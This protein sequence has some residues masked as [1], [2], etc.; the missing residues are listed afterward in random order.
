MPAP[1]DDFVGPPRSWVVRLGVPLASYGVYF[2]TRYWV[3]PW[4]QRGPFAFAESLAPGPRLLAGHL[5]TWQAPQTA[6]A[7]LTFFLLVRTG[8]LKWPRGVSLAS[9]L[10]WGVV[11]GLAITAVTA[12]IWFLAGPGF[13][14][15]VNFWKMAGNLVSNYYEELAFR[16]LLFGATLYAFRSFWPAAILSGLA[17]GL[18]HTQYPLVFRVFATTV[19]VVWA[20]AYWRTR[21][22]LS[23]WLS[24][25]LSDMLLDTF[26]KG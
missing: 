18:G 5:L 20:L 9:T 12:A 8:V 23:P 7:A 26:L 10:R 22:L 1:L 14:V 6:V 13:Q 16:G 19:G 4:L 15:D 3:T 21:T 2:A 11:S 24:H 17:F 25:Q